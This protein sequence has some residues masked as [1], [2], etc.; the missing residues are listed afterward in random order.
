MTW[1]IK[2]I[3]EVCEVIAGQSPEGKNYNNS[4]KGLPFY[5]GKKD[6]GNIFIKPPNVWTTQ[7]TKIAEKDDILMSVRAPVGPVN[8]STEKICIGRG[9]A[10]IRPSKEIDRDFLFNYF[11]KIETEL[12]GNKGAVFNSINKAQIEDLNIP[13]PNIETQRKVVESINLLFEELDKARNLLEQNLENSYSLFTSYLNS[14]FENK[15]LN[16]QYKK[17]K[18]VALDFG[19]G[20]S[21]HRPRNDASLYGGEYPFIQTGDIRNTTRLVTKF[22]QT[23][24]DKGL[25]QSKLWA[26]GT[27]CI[28]I[29]ANIAEVGILDFEA[30]FPDS[31]IGIVVNPEITTN[32]FV[33]YILLFAQAILKE[34]GKGSAQDNINLGTFEEM[35]FP[36]PD[37]SLQE[38]IVNTLNILSNTLENLSELYIHKLELISE[39]KKSILNKAFAGELVKN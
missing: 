38:E 31:V 8:I 36:F 29:A 35:T 9:L 13:L 28:T 22:T 21:K 17:L 24:N 6:F 26:K 16:W 32:D 1:A 39:L 37:L 3:G 20:K 15:N 11:L 33:Y 19:R 23:Y 34:K 25:K 18:E 4:M 30:C 10:A 12:V 27:L 5:Q 14:I 7:N 2:K